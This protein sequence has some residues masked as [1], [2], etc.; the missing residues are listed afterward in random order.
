MLKELFWKKH[1][2][3]YKKYFSSMMALKHTITIQTCLITKFNEKLVK[4]ENG[5]ASFTRLE[6]MRVIS[7]GCNIS[8][9]I[10]KNSKILKT[11]FL[12]FKKRWELVLSAH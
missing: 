10:A 11:V 12:S 9:N 6:P 7:M 5:S 3:D 1:P 4:Q 8:S 2:A